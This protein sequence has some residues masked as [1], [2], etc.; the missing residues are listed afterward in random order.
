MIGEKV[1]AAKIHS[2]EEERT[3]VDFRDFTADVRYEAAELPPE[4]ERRCLQFVHS[5]SL[6]F[7]ALDLI[8]TP[9]G[10]YV[11]LENNPVGQFLFV[12]ELVPALAM[13]DA[14]AEDLLTGAAAQS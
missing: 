5:Y 12:E 9:E 11:F 2:Q 14:V 1:F 13:T 3:R 8:V 6:R 7:G 4:V 10:R